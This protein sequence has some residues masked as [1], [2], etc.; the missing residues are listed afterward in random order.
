MPTVCWPVEGD[1]AEEWP[2]CPGCYG[3]VADEVMIV[4]GPAYCFG[5]CQGCDEWFSVR[6]LSKR[7]G[8]GRYSSPVGLCPG[9]S[10][11]T[12]T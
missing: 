9:C 3:E 11:G 10:G 5:T 1:W 6:D 8:G 2:L 4:P 12:R 7:T